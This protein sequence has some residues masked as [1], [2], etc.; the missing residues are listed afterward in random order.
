MEKEIKTERE[1]N[2]G[3]EAN[4]NEAFYKYRDSFLN[5]AGAHVPFAEFVNRGIVSFRKDATLKINMSLPIEETQ[6]F[7]G[8]GTSE[9]QNLEELHIP[10]LI[11]D[12]LDEEYFNKAIIKVNRIVFD[13]HRVL[14]DTYRLEA[15]SEEKQ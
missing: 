10:P 5:S 2:P 11:K 12:Y 14:V 1:I 7:L 8:A 13:A 6:K 15:N 9:F 3:K 4:V